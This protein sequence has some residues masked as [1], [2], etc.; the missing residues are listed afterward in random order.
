MNVSP[1][2]PTPT[3]TPTTGT[4]SAP[5]TPSATEHEQR[6]GGLDTQLPAF[7]RNATWLQA[8][9]GVA[10]IAL[11]VLVLVWPG[12]TL[13]VIGVLFGIYLLVTGFFQLM[14]GFAPHVPGHLRA[15]T[16][17]S[18]AFSVLLGLICFRGAAESIL[19]LAIWIGFG[20][21]LR[22]T[23]EIANGISARRG[24]LVFVGAITLIAGIV[25]IVSPFGSLL[26][27]TLV[28]G[29]WLVVVGVI[30]LVHGIYW[31]LQERRRQH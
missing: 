24:W 9:A 13:V 1:T 16:L 12:P 8:V 11:G 6:A 23:M 19:L 17:I 15:L 2:E 4:P 26:T 29:I 27:L 28:A 20:W 18:G 3:G 25:L 5:G 7:I 22:G 10:A 30:E 31:F 14:E 21:L